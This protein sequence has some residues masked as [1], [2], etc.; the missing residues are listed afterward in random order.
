MTIHVEVRYYDATHQQLIA[1]QP[2]AAAAQQL[3]STGALLSE[4]ELLINSLFVE[5]KNDVIGWRTY[6]ELAQK[7]PGRIEQFRDYFDLSNGT[8]RSNFSDGH[9]TD[10]NMTERVGVGTT[11]SVANRIFGLHEADWARIRE[12]TAEKTLDFHM[13]SDGQ[14][15]IHV[16]SKGAI[17]HNVL[18]KTGS[19]PHHKGSILAK[20]AVAQHPAG[21][22]SPALLLGL[23][24]AIPT[25]LDERAVCW[26]VDPP[27]GPSPEDARKYKLLARMTF[28]LRLLQP[29]TSSA[30]LIALADRIEAIYASRDYTSLDGTPLRSANQTTFSR[31]PALFRNKTVVELNHGKR[32]GRAFGR[33][34]EVGDEDIAYIGVD[35][36]VYRMLAGQ[37]FTEIL[38]YSSVYRMAA[39]EPR[40]VEAVLPA[41]PI[42]TERM[43]GGRELDQWRRLT[44][45][46]PVQVLGSGLTVGTLRK[47]PNKAVD[48][49]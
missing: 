6:S 1:S 49:R 8:I 5:H 16:E 32:D 39:P 36:D 34:F 18:N 24:A 45:V 23:I 43:P 38:E 29:L 35:S 44:A 2:Y 17:V 13:A 47:R 46:G 12:S 48:A 15:L 33:A 40:E 31:L 28:Y 11:L 37:R 4:Q 42:R 27:R 30:L 7:A 20:K 10:K 26:L 41:G 22:N 14:R 25:S 9:A 19:I 3:V 21:A